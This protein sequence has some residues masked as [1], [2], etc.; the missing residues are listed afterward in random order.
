MHDIYEPFSHQSR[1]S[2]GHC[3]VCDYC[4]FAALGFR[5]PL[6]PLRLPNPLVRASLTQLLVNVRHLNIVE[7][8]SASAEKTYERLQQEFTL[9]RRRTTHS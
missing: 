9:Y 4:D 3:R 1:H 7:G 2:I 8:Q 5:L 6:I